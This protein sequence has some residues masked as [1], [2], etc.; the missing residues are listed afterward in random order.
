[1]LEMVVVQVLVG[2]VLLVLIVLLQVVREVIQ[3]TPMKVEEVEMLA[4]VI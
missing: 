1:M 4:V 2:L 3:T